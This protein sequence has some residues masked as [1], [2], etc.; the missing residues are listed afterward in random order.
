MKKMNFI[1]TL[2]LSV[3]SISIIG[4]I[5]K[6]SEKD[7]TLTDKEIA[8][9]DSLFN[10]WEK[11]ISSNSKTKYSSN[12][13]T[14]TTLPQFKELVIMGKKIIPCIIERFEKDSNSF[15]AIPL[16]NELQDN[17]ELKSYSKISEQ[18]KV[19]EIISKFKEQE[20]AKIK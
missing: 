17:K 19:K 6:P 16:Y 15:F 20:R 5:S 9:F 7:N 3:W 11:E 10:A 8:R 4:C 2:L 12:T 14:Y 1:K 18:E 13:Q